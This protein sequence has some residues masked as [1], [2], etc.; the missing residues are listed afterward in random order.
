VASGAEIAAAVAAKHAA[1]GAALRGLSDHE[2]Q[3][4][5]RLPDWNRLTVLCHIRYGA[6]AINRLVSAARAGEP[7]LF[8]PGGRAEQRP[9]TLVPAPGETPRDVVESFVANSAALDETLA[10]VTDWSLMSREPEGVSDLGAM[11]IERLAILRLTEVEVH[12][13]DMDIGVDRWSDTFVDAALSMRFDRLALRLSNSPVPTDRPN[14]TWLLRSTEGDAW[15]VSSSADGVMSRPA[16]PDEP[17]NG[18]IEATRR[19]LLALLLG[20]SFEGVVNYGG[21]DDGAFARR[22]KDAFP[23]P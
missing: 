9:L 14:G 1:I 22:F 18:L 17:A 16:T 19:D 6:D 8:Y 20:R 15:L 2:L 4:A 12:G 5:S 21:D 3:A 13:T 11:P 23:G 7:A 10:T